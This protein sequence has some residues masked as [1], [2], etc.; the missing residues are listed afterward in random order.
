M[1]EGSKLRILPFEYLRKIGRYDP[2][3][4]KGFNGPGYPS[5]MMEELRSLAEEKKEVTFAA[6]SR[7]LR[8]GFIIIET[9]PGK[10][11]TI[12]SN[13]VVKA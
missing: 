13:W 10:T 8:K 9:Y 2:E 1:K 12:P 5:Y 3:I 11:W 4:H 6:K 7:W